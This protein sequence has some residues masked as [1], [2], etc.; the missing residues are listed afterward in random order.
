MMIDW[1][2]AGRHVV[3]YSAGAATMG[4]GVAALVAAQHGISPDQAAQVSTYLNAM[5]EGVRSIIG[6]VG[7]FVG[8]A[9]G[10]WAMWTTTKKALASSLANDP[11]TLV[12]TDPTTAKAVPKP[13]VISAA[14]VTV[15]S[16]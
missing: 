6:G 3:T 8:G 10:L 13:N 12:L 2:A 4:A 1:K 16:K 14:D 11:A 15:T 9:M 5:A 7:G